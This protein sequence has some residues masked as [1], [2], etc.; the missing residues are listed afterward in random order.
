M[1][2]SKCI[3]GYDELMSFGSSSDLT[4]YDLFFVFRMT[5]DKEL[6]MAYIEN[7]CYL[8]GYCYD[9]LTKREFERRFKPRQDERSRY[10][11]LR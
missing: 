5:P 2:Y 7:K 8:P 9:P 3:T 10:E 4:K 1:D 11:D 6:I